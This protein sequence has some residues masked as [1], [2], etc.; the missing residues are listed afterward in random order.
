MIFIFSI[1]AGVQ[2]SVTFLLYSKATQSHIHTYI[3]FL[4][5][6][7]SPSICNGA[8]LP[9]TSLVSPRT[10]SLWLT[11]SLIKMQSFA[12]VKKKAGWEIRYTASTLLWVTLCVWC[13][14]VCVSVCVCWV[15]DRGRRERGDKG[16]VFSFNSGADWE[17]PLVTY[18]FQ[19]SELL[20]AKA[21]F[22]NLLSHMF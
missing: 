20:Q 15:E 16:G 18:L 13:V 21:D 22:W 3:L 8:L 17:N 14:C 12:G 10:Q 11:S 1:V 4:T 6:S 19:S 5:L 2:C 7:L 9:S